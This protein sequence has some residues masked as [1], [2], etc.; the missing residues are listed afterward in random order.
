MEE[1]RKWVA[2]GSWRAWRLTPTQPQE[3]TPASLYPLPQLLPRRPLGSDA[4]SSEEYLRPAFEAL[5]KS[6]DDT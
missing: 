5:I 2:G 1:F 6:V 4:A 3:R